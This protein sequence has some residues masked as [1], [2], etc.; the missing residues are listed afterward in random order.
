MF[1]PANDECTDGRHCNCKASW[2]YA[3]YV[4]FAMCFI[5]YTPAVA[6]MQYKMLKYTICLLV[7]CCIINN[8][9][10]FYIENNNERI[11]AAYEND[12]QTLRFRGSGKS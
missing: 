7:M 12:I 10:L 6:N 1:Y 5:Y 2:Q 8:N 11:Q 3:P 9:S 4:G